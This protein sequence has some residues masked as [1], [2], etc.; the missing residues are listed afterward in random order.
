VYIKEKG[1]YF[2]FFSAKNAERAMENTSFCEKRRK[3]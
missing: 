2:V 1:K 3:K